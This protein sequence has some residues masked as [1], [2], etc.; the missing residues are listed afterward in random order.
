MTEARWAASAHARALVFVDEFVLDPAG[1]ASTIWIDG[2]DGHH[3]QRVRRLDVGESIV[4]ADG[5]GSWYPGRITQT[6]Q[7]AVLVERVGPIGQEPTPTPRLTVGFAPAK[8][9]HGTDVVHQL[10]ELGVDRIIP[11]VTHRSVV[12][13]DGDRGTKA[14][15]R[16]RRVAR[17]AAMQCH[18]ARIPAV[19]PPTTL[20]NLH[21]AVGLLIGDPGGIRAEEVPFPDGGEWLAII[22]PEGGFAPEELASLRTTIRVRVGPHVLRSVTAPVAIAAALASRRSG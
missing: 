15:D 12:R 11:L 3:L 22:G 18:R 1:G 7:G 14:L 19:D 17:E 5:R 21:G 9:D 6:R 8:R 13:W 10:V 2:T 16:M 20:A 4:V